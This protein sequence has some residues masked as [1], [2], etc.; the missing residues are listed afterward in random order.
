MKRVIFLATYLVMVG[1]NQT[2]G[3]PEQGYAEKSIVT[4]VGDFVSETYHSWFGDDSQKRPYP[5]MDEWG[6]REG[7]YNSFYDPCSVKPC[8]PK[9]KEDGAETDEDRKFGFPLKKP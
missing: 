6:N 2:N 7:V 4:K 1:C 8:P 9:S 3:Q 5:G